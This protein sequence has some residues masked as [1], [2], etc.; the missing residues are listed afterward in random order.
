MTEKQK[1]LYLHHLDT[2]KLMTT[3]ATP[4]FWVLDLED[5]TGFELASTLQDPSRIAEARNLTSAQGS[6]PA[7][8]AATTLE[9]ANKTLAALWS[10]PPM[11][12]G[13]YMAVVSDGSLTVLAIR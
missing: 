11:P 6:I 12:K 2:A 1:A 8:T 13:R 7:M 5:E 9:S 3:T 10:R 4:V